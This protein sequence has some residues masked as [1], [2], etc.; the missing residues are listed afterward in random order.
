MWD[1][2]VLYHNDDIWKTLYHLPLTIGIVGES[3]S[4][5]STITDD[6]ITVLNK[7]GITTT[8]I[9]SD[10][11]YY[12]NSKAVKEAGSFANWAKDKDLDC[13][14][15]MDLNLMKQH[16]TTLKNNNCVWLPKYDMSGTAIRIDNYTLANPSD[17]IISEGLFTMCLKEAFDITIY[18]HI[19]EDVQKQRWYER[20]IFRNLGDSM[21]IMYQRAKDRALQYIIPHKDTCDIILSGEGPRPKYKQLMEQVLRKLK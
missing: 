19:Q 12:D 5:K 18:V 14:E 21:D 20:A 10:D 15:A 13:P 8:R 6:F 16:I 11:Y 2:L 1:K 9:N 3:A 4:G 17:V 7:H